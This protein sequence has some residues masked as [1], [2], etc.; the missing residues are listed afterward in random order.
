MAPCPPSP[1]LS[2]G[3]PD[4]PQHS[5]FSSPPR[6][7]SFHDR[8]NIEGRSTV[9]SRRPVHQTELLTR[10][11]L[12]REAVKVHSLKGAPTGQVTG[13]AGSISPTIGN[14]DGMDEEPE[15]DIAFSG[16]NPLFASARSSRRS[17][18]PSARII[19]GGSVGC[20][21]ELAQGDFSLPLEGPMFNRRN[22]A[23]P[24]GNGRSGRI[25]LIKTASSRPGPSQL[26]S[27]I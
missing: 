20:G 26:A 10:P 8:L 27:P 5:L 13:V 15:F 7:R 24:L 4:N 19:R 2:R 16:K 6:S 3:T 25:G 11:W 21:A 23:S 12:A 1:F 18:S 14:L 17:P 9:T 22:T